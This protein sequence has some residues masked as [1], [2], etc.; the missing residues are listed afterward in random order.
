M[1]LQFR[2]LKCL[3]PCLQFGIISKSKVVRIGYLLQNFKGP[4]IQNNNYDLFSEST[5]GKWCRGEVRWYG[6]TAPGLRDVRGDVHLWGMQ[7]EIDLH[8]KLS[9][10]E[11]HK[12]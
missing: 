8:K 9:G 7:C 4:I 2:C 5:D 10:I 3:I 1:G 6:K 12:A 11:E